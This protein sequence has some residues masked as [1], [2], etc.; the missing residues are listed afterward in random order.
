MAEFNDDDD[1]GND[2]ELTSWDR[3]VVAAIGVVG[4]A[5]NGAMVARVV[6]IVA[7]AA[8]LIGSAI[9][10]FWYQESTYNPMTGLDSS[11]WK[12]RWTL[13]GFGLFLQYLAAPLAFAAIVFA[14]SYTVEVAAA[15]LDI[16]IVL[17]D[18]DDDAESE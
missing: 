17:A 8:A 5:R 6:S 13:H 3:R 11:E 7:A 16:D 9:A 18:D 2:V 10:A 15:R 4:A 1:T 14:L 12:F